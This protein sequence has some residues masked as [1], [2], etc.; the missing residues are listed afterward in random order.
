M[1]IIQSPLFDFEAFI[2][3]KSN[4]RLAMVLEAI[5]AEGL[6]SVL[7]KEHWTGRRG[8]SVRG[9]WSALIAGVLADAGSLA[10]VVR[11]LR[12]DK[13]TRIICGFSEGNLPSQDAL[14]RF[15]KKLVI[16]GDLLEKCFADL[17]KELR[18]LLP[19]FG[20]KL[21]VDST[22]IKAYANGHRQHPSDGDAR[23]EAKGGGHHARPAEASKGQR[24]L[25]YWFGY[26][27]HLI[28]DVCY[29]LPVSFVLTPANE[30]DTTH[31]E[32]LL[33][34][35]GA[36]QPETR[37][38]A[39]IADKGYDSQSN[40]NFIYNECQAAPIIP[41]RVVKDMQ[42]P[43]ICND[44]GTPI[45]SCGLEMTYWGKDGRYLKY[46]CPE[47]VGKGTCKS[48]FKCTSSPYGY[49]LK[50]PIN[51]DPRRHPPIPRESP[52]WQRLYRLRS[53]IERVNSRLKELLGLRS[54]TVR[55]I[56]KVTVKAMLSLLV[57]AAAAVGMARRHRLSE[58]RVIVT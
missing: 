9:M 8:Y 54:I 15:L 39:V 51:N 47:A 18:Q 32:A 21:A 26:K 10:D 35:A 53:A 58:L 37:P 28:V 42:M 44:K 23:W 5:P 41:I 57:M 24:D 40:Y 25:Y 1:H 2:E 6:I 50:L 31:M 14:G 4:D 48:R 30:S 22:D 45:C 52:K 13:D 29:E 55:G 49:V 46:R 34:K 19:G 33:K 56:A 11:L 20:T 16:H 38:Q 12:R 43:D 7:E 3:K 17:A 27:L 36:D